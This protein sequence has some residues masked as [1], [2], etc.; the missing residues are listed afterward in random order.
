[1]VVYS[2]LDRARRISNKLGI[3][4]V[5]D[6]IGVLDVVYR[7]YWRV[8]WWVSNSEKIELEIGDARSEFWP[9]DWNDFRHLDSEFEEGII[10]DVV[11]KTSPKDV[12]WDVGAHIGIY[13][14]LVGSVLDR[15]EVVAFEPNPTMRQRLNS[16]VAHNELSNVT[17]LPHAVSDRDEK[18]E[19]AGWE[20]QEGGD[21]TGDPVELVK[22]D[23]IAVENA[24]PNPTIV[25]IDIEG[26]EIN[27]LR[28][29]DRMLNESVRLV[30]V[31][32]HPDRIQG[33]PGVVEELLVDAGFTDVQRFKETDGSIY[34]V[35]A[36]K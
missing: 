12:F 27:A 16:N 22:G 2:L 20:V 1:M 26:E 18:G 34:H 21:G 25:K 14:C 4:G 5:L 28:G 30:Y 36:V 13:T 32:V 17:V 24:I 15:G 33:N 19:M 9:V 7:T 6:S 10:R 31:E 3:T 23:S 29:L 11:E 8:A 35:R